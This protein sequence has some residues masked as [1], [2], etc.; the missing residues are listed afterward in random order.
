MQCPQQVEVSVGIYIADYDGG[1]P[2]KI[3]PK[4]DEEGVAFPEDCYNFGAGP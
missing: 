4:P 1:R 3:W 2:C